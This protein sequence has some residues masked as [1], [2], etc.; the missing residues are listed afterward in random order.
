MAPAVLRMG[1][2]MPDIDLFAVVVNGNNQPIF[3]PRDIEDGKFSHLVCGGE[4]DP[5][6]G[7]RGIG[8]FTDGGIPMI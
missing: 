8:G 2:H 1:E 6:F 3:V 7:E 5:Q 4:R